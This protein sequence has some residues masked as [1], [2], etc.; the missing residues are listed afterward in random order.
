MCA[1]ALAALTLTFGVGLLA[2]LLRRPGLALVA[3]ECHLQPRLLIDRP[4]SNSLARLYHA[5]CYFQNEE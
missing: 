3:R 1:D 2:E 4:V 5:Q